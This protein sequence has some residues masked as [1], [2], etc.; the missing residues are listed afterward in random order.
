[1]DE[2]PAYVTG[3]FISPKKIQYKG[4]R[5]QLVT[6]QAIFHIRKIIYLIVIFPFNTNAN[7]LMRVEPAS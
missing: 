3:H 5:V 7:S 2:A 6:K 4:S 1:M